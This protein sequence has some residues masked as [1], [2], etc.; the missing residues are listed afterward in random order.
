MGDTTAT[1]SAD[2]TIGDTTGT[3]IDMGDII[4]TTTDTVGKQGTPQDA[5]AYREHPRR[6]RRGWLAGILSGVLLL[7]APGTALWR[8][9]GSIPWPHHKDP[10]S[11]YTV[12]SSPPVQGTEGGDQGA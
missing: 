3:R 6:H 5:G 11:R 8:A 7:S 4:I 10:L 1:L 9:A 2:T 12:L